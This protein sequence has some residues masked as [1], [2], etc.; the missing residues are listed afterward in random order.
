SD[1]MLPRVCLCGL[2]CRARLVLIDEHM[3]V[4]V[5][6]GAL[7]IWLFGASAIL[8]IH[9]PPGPIVI[10]SLLVLLALGLRPPGW[11][12]HPQRGT[13]PRAAPLES[14]TEPHIASAVTA[15]DGGEGTSSGGASQ[16]ILAGGDAGGSR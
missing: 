15:L 11:R 4:C 2:R 13:H 8:L 9:L 7:A 5:M 16:N 3:V 10:L 1:R 6:V 14:T 12:M